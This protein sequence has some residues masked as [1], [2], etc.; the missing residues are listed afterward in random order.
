MEYE[1][2]SAGKVIA[3]FRHLADRDACLDMFR[4]MYEDCEFEKFDL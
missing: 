1:I 3:V 4:E 2:H